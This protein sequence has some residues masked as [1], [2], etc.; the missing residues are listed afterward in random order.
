MEMKPLAVDGPSVR[1]RNLDTAV[2]EP[3]GLA[4]GNIAF[5]EKGSGAPQHWPQKSHLFTFPSV[6]ISI[7]Q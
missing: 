5:Q 3:T 7:M 1:P 6:R 4:D 2:V